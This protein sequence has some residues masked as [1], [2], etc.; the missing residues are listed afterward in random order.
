M[1]I[2]ALSVPTGTVIETEVCI[3]GAGA[4]GIGLAREF[5]NSNFRVVLLESGG[6]ELETVTQDLYA[7]SNIGRPYYDPTVHR[8]RYFGGTTN[9]WGGWCALPDSLDFE[10]R[11]GVPYSGWPFSRSY[12]EP[13]YRRAQEVCQLGPFGYEASDWGIAPSD[14]PEPFR[15]PHFVCQAIQVS[16]PTRFGPQ[17]AAELRQ[18]RNLSVYLHANALHFDTSE[19]GGDV[20]QLN[21][22]VL[23][24]G[25]LSVRAR[26][27]ILATGGIENARLLLLSDEHGGVGLGNDHGLVGRFFMVHLE[28]TG[29]I[30]ALANPYMD[31]TF[32][33][34]E[35]GADYNRFGVARRFVSYV[36]LSE[37][38]R[39]ELKLPHLRFRFVYT[40]PRAVE[41]LKRLILRTDHGAD[42]LSDLGSV[43]RDLDGVAT[44]VERRKLFGRVAPN[45]PVEAVLLKATSEQMPNSESRIE[46]SRELDVFGLRKVT[47]DWELTAEDKRGMAIGHRMFGAELGRAGFGRF[48]PTVSEDDINWPKDMY[49]DPHNMGTTRM[50]QNPSLG[51]VD[52]NCRVHGVA[53]LYVAG[54]SVFPTSGAANPTLTI[55][56]LAL[57]LADHI[58]ERLR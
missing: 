11:E 10:T 12:L 16:P 51:V 35:F 27:Y 33:T 40:R 45:A 22:G 5:T 17:Y 21:V 49:G 23:P 31:L 18:A 29:G 53:N 44:Y 52:E 26:I 54:S 43:M 1:F 42:I 6:T 37:K 48:R 57:R 47:I 32:Q 13:W 58:K 39:R 2:D 36:C 34:G 46:L 25:R 38:T 8:L 56:A 4:A 9:H 14:I 24:D 41:A 7:G 19:N 55:V 50:H 30:I 28:Y 20:R 15:G 3:V